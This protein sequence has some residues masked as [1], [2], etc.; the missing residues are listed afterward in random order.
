MLGGLPDPGPGPGSLLP[1][2]LRGEEHG[3]RVG[4][5]QRNLLVLG[6]EELDEA[7]QEVRALLHLALPGFQQILGG[8]EG[9]MCHVSR[10]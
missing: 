9:K 4:D 2:G 8:G 3:V 10:S 7:L 1:D 5:M 6:M